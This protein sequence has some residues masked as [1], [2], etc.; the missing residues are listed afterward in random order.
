M[1]IIEINSL[2]NGSHRNQSGYFRTV[3]DGWAVIPPSMTTEN[4]PFGEVAAE[5]VNGVMTVTKWTPGTVPEPEPEPDPEP[6]TEERV[7]ALEDENATLKAQITAQ[8]D[9]MDFYEDCIAEM[10]SI[11][12]A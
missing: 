12:Y 10:A 7:A 9:Q 4:F 6:T 11:V 1:K 5:E 2:D 8:S 3:P